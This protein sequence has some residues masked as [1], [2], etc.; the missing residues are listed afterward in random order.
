[1]ID[2]NFEVERSQFH[3]VRIDVSDGIEVDM[4]FDGGR[5]FEGKT[6]KTKSWDG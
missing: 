1:M 3:R 2:P 6:R 5:Q 4:A